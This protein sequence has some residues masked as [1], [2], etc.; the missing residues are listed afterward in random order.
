ME[1]FK[2]TKNIPF[3]GSDFELIILTFRC[4]RETV[5]LLVAENL[6]VTIMAEDIGKRR[7]QLLLSV[8][9]RIVT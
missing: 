7:G 8:K 3:I 2:I 5:H 4:V 6:G 9:S 1:T